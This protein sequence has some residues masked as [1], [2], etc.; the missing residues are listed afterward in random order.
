VSDSSAARS[1]WNLGALPWRSLLPCLVILIFSIQFLF[2]WDVESWHRFWRSVGIA[3]LIVGVPWILFQNERFLTQLWAGPDETA[4][5]RDV[6]WT[7]NFV[8]AFILAGGAILL[9]YSLQFALPNGNRLRESLS[10][11]GAGG[12]LA[13]ASLMGGALVG[14]IFGI[15][16][17]LREPQGDR[18]PTKSGQVEGS[19]STDPAT[20]SKAEI[21]SRTSSRSARFQANTNLEEI[22]DWLTKIIVGLG[23]TKLAKI[24]EYVARM[25]AFATDRLGASSGAEL[26]ENVAFSLMAAFSVGGFFMGYLMTRLYLPRAL[27]S[28]EGPEQK[29]TEEVDFA[30][31]DPISSGPVPD[32]AVWGLGIRRALTVQRASEGVN[33]S[34]I[35]DQVRRLA[36][37][38][39]LLRGSLS[40]GDERTNQMEQVAAQMKSLA[41]AVQPFLSE[42]KKSTSPGERLAAVTA[43]EVRPQED[44]LR[45]LVE[46]ID[47]EKPFIGYH[48][49]LALL[50]AIRA[51]TIPAPGGQVAS[52]AV[53]GSMPAQGVCDAIK[54]AI[55]ILD[56][57]GLQRTDRYRVLEAAK[58]EGLCEGN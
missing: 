20:A 31:A 56:G 57:K 55:G 13:L 54:E 53:E 43:L 32:A 18:A 47:V 16:R 29:L 46:R 26:T 17:F 4:Q 45:W 9:L 25:T 40:P 52:V 28:A 7:R 11:F 6:R 10:L 8:L 42:L 14:F 19:R 5:L 3:T 34:A 49:A 37:N 36:K 50:S 1:R 33:Q 41:L 35:R 27:N 48:A 24:P 51:S 38:Y 30:G 44:S 21:A 22:S 15:P 2:P 12:L 39:E 23:L 58:K